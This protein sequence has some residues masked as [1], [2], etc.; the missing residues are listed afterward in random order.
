MAQHDPKL[1]EFLARRAPPTEYQNEYEFVSV[2]AR[3]QEVRDSLRKYA[4]SIAMWFAGFFSRSSAQNPHEWAALA[5]TKFDRAFTAY[6]KRMG[7]KHPPAYKF[8]TYFVWSEFHAI[9]HQPDQTAADASVKM[10]ASGARTDCRGFCVC[11]LR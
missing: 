9:S 10:K 4:E 3:N 1:T 8:T 7:S 11:R 6:A 5:M 2:A